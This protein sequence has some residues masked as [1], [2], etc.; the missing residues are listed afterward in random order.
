MTPAV[1]VIAYSHF[2]AAR[3]HNEKW[4]CQC[5]NCQEFRKHPELVR[6]AEENIDE[7]IEN[8]KSVFSSMEKP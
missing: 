5:K 8:F 1:H 6:Q 4:T 3:R 2:Y 7:R